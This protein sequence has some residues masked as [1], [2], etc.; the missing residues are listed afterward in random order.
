[1]LFIKKCIQLYIKPIS[2]QSYQKQKKE[3]PKERLSAR[4]SMSHLC[5]SQSLTPYT[6]D[7][8]WESAELDEEDATTCAKG[9]VITF[10]LRGDTH[11]AFTFVCQSQAMGNSSA[12]MRVFMVLSANWMSGWA[13]RCRH[14]LLLPHEFDTGKFVSFYPLQWH[15]FF[16]MQYC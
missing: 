15:F 9:P 13:S 6:R 16:S 11:F 5:D 14:N 12:D 4:S 7:L 1:M 10:G 2:H 3:R 8:I